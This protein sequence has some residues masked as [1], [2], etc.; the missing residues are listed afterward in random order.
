MQET[1]FLPVCS[2]KNK[3]EKCIK[4]AN[5]FHARRSAKRRLESIRRLK[6]ELDDLKTEHKKAIFEHDLVEAANSLYRIEI[7]QKVN[8]RTVVIR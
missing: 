5:C 1:L 2:K 6:Q 7:G 4:S 8:Q 3:C